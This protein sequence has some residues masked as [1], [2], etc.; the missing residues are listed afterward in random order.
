MFANFTAYFVK[1]KSSRS[2]P[3]SIQ[4]FVS[5]LFETKSDPTFKIFILDLV[6]A[7]NFY[8]IIIAN[9]LLRFFAKFPGVSCKFFLLLFFYYYI[10]FL[11]I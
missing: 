8:R 10:L 11:I 2:V 1:N 4:F 7:S 3:K 6:L 9:F 5:F